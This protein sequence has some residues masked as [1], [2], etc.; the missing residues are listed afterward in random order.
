M[1]NTQPAIKTKKKLSKADWVSV[2]DYICQEYTD[3][4]TRRKDKEKQW[5]EVDRQI[6]MEPDL[7]FKKLSNGKIDNK[8][9]W[10]S[11]ME[12]PLQ[13]QTLEVLTADARRMM[14]PGNGA[15]FESNAALTDEYLGRAD[16]GAIIAGDENEVPSKLNQDNAN[17]LVQGYLTNFHRQYDFRGNVDQINAESFKYGI[18]VGRARMA[19]KTS[20]IQNASGV[21]KEDKKIPVLFPRSIKNTYLDDSHHKMLNEG[22]IVGESVIDESW[23]VLDDLRMAAKKGSKEPTDMDGGWMAA[24]LKGVEPDKDGR[25][26]VLEYE[27]DLLIPQ[28]TS[29][30]IFI[31]GV[32]VTV[33]NGGE[34]KRVVR[35]RERQ[36]PFGSNILF[37]YHREECGD[38]YATGPLMKGRPI[39][40]AATNALNR[41]LDAAALQNAPPAQYSRDDQAFAQTGGPEIHPFAKWGTLDPVNFPIIGNPGPMLQAYLALVQQYADMTG[42]NAPRLGQKTSSHTTAF[43]KD[44]ENQRGVARTVDYVSSTGSG[45]LTQWLYM[46]YAMAMKSFKGKQSFYIDSYRGYVDIE[47]KHLPDTVTFEWFGSAG[48]AEEQAREQ[49]KLQSGQL[50]ISL[51]QFAIQQGKQPTIS[52]PDMIQEVLTQGGWTDTDA[53]TN[54]EASLGGVEGAPAV[55]GPLEGNPDAA[56]EALSTL[57]G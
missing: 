15:W 51:D 38:P 55:G 47:K 26:H 14:F 30:A 45:P 49:K 16:F 43:A 44:V 6:R 18:G 3:R 4:K 21:V 48:P 1:P 27:G 2:A 12:L 24:H 31:A 52:L 19:Q 9:L 35:F 32:I 13:A 41:M 56:I 46:E 40:I 10:M 39:Q 34:N 17:K 37:P 50:A 53:I 42:V 28:K 8:K 29:R 5:S 7:A 33:V 25:V 57:Q 22:H 20:F 23:H 36:F 54:S 11:E